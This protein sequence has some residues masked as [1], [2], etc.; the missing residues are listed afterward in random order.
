MGS[1]INQNRRPKTNKGITQE[2]QIGEKLGSTQEHILQSWEAE[3]MAEEGATWNCQDWGSEERPGGPSF[4]QAER[5]G[6]LGSPSDL[7]PYFSL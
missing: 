6:G 4:S 5:V 1:Q 2:K 7:P 3:V